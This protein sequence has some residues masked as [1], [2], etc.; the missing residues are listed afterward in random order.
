MFRLGP[1]RLE[2]FAAHTFF[3]ASTRI[4]ADFNGAARFRLQYPDH[5]GFR[6]QEK[7]LLRGG[8][9]RALNLQVGGVF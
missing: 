1:F 4:I 6:G 2:F 3:L 8:E 9:N 7:D 5:I